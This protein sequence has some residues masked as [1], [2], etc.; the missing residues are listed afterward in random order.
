MIDEA[1]ANTD[2]LCL[3]YDINAFKI[4]ASAMHYKASDYLK[5][6]IT[7]SGTQF[8]EDISEFK[9]G[10][11]ASDIDKFC[12]ALINLNSSQIYDWKKGCRDYNLTRN[13]INLDFLDLG[14]EN[15]NS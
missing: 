13:K 7:F 15:T 11:V 9:S 6:V 4:R 3:P 14:Y 8:A 12:E 2:I 5:P 10:F 1:L